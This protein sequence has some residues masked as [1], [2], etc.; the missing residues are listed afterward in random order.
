MTLLI[1]TGVVAPP[2]RVEFWAQSSYDVYH[3]LQIQSDESERFSARMWGDWL[4]C[5]GF[6]RIAAESNTM[7][8]TPADIAAGDPE[9]LHLSVLLRG[10]R[11]VPLRHA[12][13]VSD[14]RR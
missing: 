13:Q 4:S 10:N 1:D 7:S 3:P 14:V 12:R 9:C 2:H 11:E 6:Y 8:R 5:V